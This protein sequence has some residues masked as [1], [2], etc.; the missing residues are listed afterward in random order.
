[1]QTAIF[2]CSCTLPLLPFTMRSE[3]HT[4]ELQSRENLVCSLLLEKHLDLRVIHSFPTRRSSDL[5]LGIDSQVYLFDSTTIDLCLS[6]FWWA[7]FRKN[8]GGIKMHTLYD[9]N[10]HIPVFMHI[11]AATIHD[12]IGRAHV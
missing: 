7:T 5:D 1:M 9:A 11:T 8:K 4:S 2:L 3:E 12:E 6:V 10:S